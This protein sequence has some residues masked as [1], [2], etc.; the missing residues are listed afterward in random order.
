MDKERRHVVVAHSLEGGLEREVVVYSCLLNENKFQLPP[1]SVLSVSNDAIQ[2]HASCLDRER[3]ILSE[4]NLV[5]AHESLHECVS[6]HQLAMICVFQID[7]VLHNAMKGGYIQ[8]GQ[9]PAQYCLHHVLHS[10]SLGTTL[11]LVAR[12]RASVSGWEMGEMG[13]MGERV[14]V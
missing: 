5:H 13:E 8:H 2:R 12:H 4:M 9:H 7:T 10:Q 6:T 14:W 1:P 3:V 11:E